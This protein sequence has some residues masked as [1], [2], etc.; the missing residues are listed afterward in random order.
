MV[1]SFCFITF[2]Y[3]WCPTAPPTSI[4]PFGFNG[5][6]ICGFCTYILTFA[7]FS[8]SKPVISTIPPIGPVP[9]IWIVILS[10][11]SF[12]SK[13][14][15]IAATVSALPAAAVTVGVKSCIFLAS[16]TNSVVSIHITDTFLL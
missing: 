11:N 12:V 9:F 14:A 8:F 13:Y 6:S 1:N 4:F 7:F 15:I 16:S 2:K 10:V 3:P 5:N